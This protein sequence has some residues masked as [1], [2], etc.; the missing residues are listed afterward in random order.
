MNLFER[1]KRLKAIQILFPLYKAR[2]IR[3]LIPILIIALLYWEGKKQIHQIHFSQTLSYLRHLPAQFV[4]L[5]LFTALASA[6]V[7]S[8]YDFLIRHR[9]KLPLSLKETFFYGWIANT[10]N[11]FLGFAGFTGAGVR[12]ILYKK[13]EVPLTVSVKSSL[14]LAPILTTGLSVMAWLAIVGVFPIGS[15]FSEHRWMPIA[16]IGMALYLPFFILL[17][18]SRLF[19]KWFHS[20]EERIPRAVTVV[21][22]GISFAEWLCAGLTFWVICTV[23]AGDLSFRTTAGIFTIAGIAGIV[24]MA[25]GGIGSFDLTALIGL[26]AAGISSEK[27][28]AVL[29]LFRLF[30]YVLPWLIGLVLITKEITPSRERMGHLTVSLWE[31]SQTRWQAFWRWPGQFRFLSDLGVWALAILVLSAGLLLLLSA[32]TPGLLYRLKFSEELFS[33][34][35]MALSNQLSV[36]VG[37]ILIVLSRGIKLRIKRAYRMTLYML[38]V[39]AFFTFAKGFDYEEALYLLAILFFLWLSRSRFDR[40]SSPFSFRTAVALLTLTLFIVFGYVII[41]TH[42]HPTFGHLSRYIPSKLKERLFYQP[43]ELIHSAIIGISGAWIFLI[44][45]FFFRPK[46]TVGTTPN[47]AEMEQLHDYL[48][49]HTGNLLTH[50]LFLRDKAFYWAMGG[51]VLI[52]YGR[53]RDKL[54]VLGDPLGPKEKIEEGIEEFQ[55]FADRYAMP[56]VFYQVSPDYLPIYHENGYRFFKLGE[57]ALVELADFSLSG[58]KK[59]GLRSARNRLAKEGFHFEMMEPPFSESVLARL[60]R[61]S[62]LWLGNKHEKGFSLGWFDKDYLQLAPIAVLKNSDEQVIAFVSLMPCYDGGKVLSIDLMR[63]L[64]D[65]PNGTMDVMFIH[66]LEWAK[67]R[68]YE[69]FNLGMA[70]L[71]S[72]GENKKA[73]REEKIARLA[74]QY[75]NYWYSFQGL[76]HYKEKFSPRWEPRYLAYPQSV[77]LPLLMLDLAL[78]VGR[79]RMKN[80]NI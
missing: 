17:Q 31:E 27:A 37:I 25:P 75:G 53:A 1:M 48:T 9:F 62:D 73:L 13:Q 47:H 74:F 79:K 54:V 56:I 36:I 43:D 23:M 70:P 12:T 50:L 77:S 72:V 57:E 49:E 46:R 6:A 60:E 3:F 41:G 5:I 44:G 21:S 39:G 58:R 28:T 11:N 15:L 35:I 24:S 30:Y 34:P 16:L 20:S 66:L 78:L 51:E 45:W 33:L 4:L 7:M 69:Q 67:E 55:E 42:V 65:V 63:H 59:S 10:F 18:Q 61:I 64:P 68:G 14:F 40:E 38:I 52:P 19:S 2:I 22:V 8:G 76:R 32:A 71:S 26:Q 29:V 80:K